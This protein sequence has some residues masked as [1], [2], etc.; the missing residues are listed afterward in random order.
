M[1]ANPVTLLPRIIRQAT[2]GWVPLTHNSPKYL[3]RNSAQE[4]VEEF[5]PLKYE[6]LSFEKCLN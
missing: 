3:E 6:I 1:I 4:K 5:F 2:K